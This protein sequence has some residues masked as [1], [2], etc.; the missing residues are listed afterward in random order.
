MGRWPCWRRCSRRDLCGVCALNGRQ[1][2]CKRLHLNTIVEG[3]VRNCVSARIIS[4]AEYLGTTIT[5]RY[6]FP[7][8][9]VSNLRQAWFVI[10]VDVPSTVAPIADILSNISVGKCWA[11]LLI[12]MSRDGQRV[13]H[14]AFHLGNGHRTRP[15]IAGSR[16]WHPPGALVEHRTNLICR[17]DNHPL[18]IHERPYY[19]DGG[20]PQE[21][22]RRQHLN[23]PASSA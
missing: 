4:R 19:G 18:R 12:G 2:V 1:A 3:E 7:A 22:G 14:L 16:C 21:Q 8:P 10:A 9:I 6:C 5:N 13:V 20:E 11:R 15:P 17:Q 23:T